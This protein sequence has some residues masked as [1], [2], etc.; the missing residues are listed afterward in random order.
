MHRGY[1]KIHRKI[2]DSFIYKDSKALHLWI[3]LI[4]EAN[5][6]DNE[7][8]FN[9]KK[10]VCKR[11]QLLTGLNSLAC[12]TK[13]NRSKVNRLLKMFKNETLIETQKTNRFTIITVLKYGQYQIVNGKSETQ[14]ETPVKLQRNS[15]ETPVK[16]NNNDNTLKN[17]NNV[18]T[19]SGKPDKP[20][21]K[22]EQDFD[23]FWSVY[24]KKKS[25]HDATRAW[26]KAKPDITAVLSALSWQKASMDWV[27]DGGQYIPYPATYINRG[28]YLDENPSQYAKRNK[29]V[30]KDI[31]I[32]PKLKDED[33]ATPEQMAEIKSRLTGIKEVPKKEMR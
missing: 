8:M 29:E 20:K 27:K 6:K 16:P 3:H 1:I 4:L 28:G 5:H 18:N 30:K 15:S 31:Y 26:K 32:E 21:S 13:I 11:G 17:V 7:F 12:E 2:Q 10:Q 33:F 24:P 22:I 14:N 25:R 19:T 23:T 9:N